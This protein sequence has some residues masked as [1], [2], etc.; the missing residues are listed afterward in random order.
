[1]ERGIKA[2]LGAPVRKR[3]T[4]SDLASTSAMIFFWEVGMAATVLLTGRVEERD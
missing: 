1:M 4:Y 2:G 3:L